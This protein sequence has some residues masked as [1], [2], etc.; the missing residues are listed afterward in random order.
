M[1]AV[2]ASDPTRSI[3]PVDALVAAYRSVVEEVDQVLEPLEGQVPKGLRGCLYRNGVGKVEVEGTPQMH[4]FDGDGMVSRFE[5]NGAEIRYRNRYVQTREWLEEQRFGAMRYRAFGTNLP[6]GRHRNILRMR[7]KN[8]ANTN[9]VWHGGRL[10]ALWEGGQPHAIDSHSLATLG[11]FD[12][13][14]ALRNRFPSSL[15][16]A[17]LPFSAHPS[18][19]PTTGD[20][21]NFGVLV[22]PTPTL[23]LYR[24]P[25]SGHTISLRRFPLRRATFMHDF[26]LTSKYAVFFA[27]PIHFDLART[28]G[29]MCAPVEAIRR[30]HGRPTEVIVVPKAGGPARTL[31]APNGFF[32]FHF[33]GAYEEGDRIVLH[34]CRMSDFQGGTV[35][36]RDSDAIRA[37][38]LDPGIPSRWTINLRTGSVDEQIFDLEPMELPTIDPRFR[39]ARHTVG[40]AT[41][42][43]RHGP[44]VY[45]MLARV[46]LATGEARV[47]RFEPDLPGEPVFVPRSTSAPEGEGWLLSVTYRAATARSELWI[48][49]AATLDT[50]ARFGLP[51][52]Q[53]PGFH[54]CFVGA[55]PPS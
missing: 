14:G 9:V 39:S 21:Y 16:T 23:I 10:L 42:R 50:V 51:H 37:V 1:I 38:R 41:A 13:D 20:L 22:G 52:H 47:K 35:D 24:S 18:V 40:W 8:A 19:C 28:L 15:I 34:G 43:E 27:T 49:D 5:I 53:P 17:E 31:E 30:D 29:G 46:D 4:P 25:R 3:D 48:L 33:F 45:T 12:F 11:R 26:A 7:F 2:N 32:L 55:S 6:G 44:A 54:G 36:L